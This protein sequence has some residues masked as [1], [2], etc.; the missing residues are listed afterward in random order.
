MAT[1]NIVFD[2]VGTLAGYDK[3]HDAMEVTLGDRLRAEGIKIPMLCY[4]WTGEAGREYTN[5]NLSGGYVPYFKVF[6]AIAFRV[7]W[8]CG[9]AEPRKFATVEEVAAI[10]KGYANLEMRPGAAECVS[11]L[12]DAGFTVWGLT[13]GDLN[14]VGG[15][16]RRSGIEMPRKN[17]VSCDAAQIGKP[18]PRAYKPL[19]D[20]LSSNG[21][22]P[23]FAAAHE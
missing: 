22:K 14:T 11:K 16:F 17:L 8:K 12:R 6:E 23:W 3:L 20:R 7:F 9:I 18:D 15:Y 2:V 19:L 1:K 21:S 5:L 13:T 10:A 4:L